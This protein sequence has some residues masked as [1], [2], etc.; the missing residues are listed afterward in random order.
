MPWSLPGHT[1][2]K[3]EAYQ[4]GFKRLGVEGII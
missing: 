1:D 2:R 4:R 3:E